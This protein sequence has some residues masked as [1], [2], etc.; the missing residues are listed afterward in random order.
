M[1]RVGVIACRCHNFIGYG[2]SLI[3]IYGMKAAQQK[4]F[5]KY[6][7]KTVCMR[8]HRWSK[9]RLFKMLG[10]I[11]INQKTLKK[12]SEWNQR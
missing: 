1:R 12:C 4:E 8:K 10:K 11:T 5:T 9:Q 3:S 7:N 6:S 2:P